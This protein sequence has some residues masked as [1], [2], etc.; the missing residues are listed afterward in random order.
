MKKYFTNI[1]SFMELNKTYKKLCFELHP[2]LGGSKE[3]FQEMVNEYE[4]LFEYWKNEN[5]RT[6]DK[7]YHTREGVKDYED[8]VDTLLNLGLNFDLVNNWIWITADKNTYPI[9][10]KIKSLGF[11]YSKPKRKFWKD[12]SGNVKERTKNYRTKKKYKDIIDTYGCQSFK[13]KEILKLQ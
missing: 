10:D 11:Q 2:D 1:N 4:Q 7:K 12:L 13:G 3:K 8:M 9:R 6:Q 5:N